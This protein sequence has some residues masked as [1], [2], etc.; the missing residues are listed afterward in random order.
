MVLD[1][2]I[3]MDP[4][5][6]IILVSVILSLTITILYKYLTDQK[7]MKSLKGEIKAYQAEMK[8][9]RDNPQKMMK[10][11]K[12]AMEANM[13]YMMHSLKPTL[14]T[15]IP[16]IFVF[17]WLNAN[18]AYYPI[19]QDQDFK[20]M[21]VFDDKA[22]SGSIELMLPSG[23][24]LVSGS[25]LLK[26]SGGVAEW[27][28]KGTKGDYSIS[29]KYNDKEYSRDIVITDNL[30]D[31]TGIKPANTKADVPELKGSGIK[32]LNIGNEKIKPLQKYPVLKSIPWIGG[33][34]WL[35]VYILLSILL[36]M[37]F[38]KVMDVY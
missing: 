17:G 22:A 38:R 4:L 12:K 19:M 1:F 18:F 5:L 3:R 32:S 13:K 25:D 29:Y 20:T 34:G 7:L 23:I 2:L 11:Q 33:F 36:S 14:F 6:S 9:L 31:R 26:F 16:I 37:L 30:Y 15:F 21:V 10:V 27:T 35:G 28:L 8:T 24:Q